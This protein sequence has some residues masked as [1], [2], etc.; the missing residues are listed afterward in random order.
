MKN[1]KKIFPKLLI[2]LVIMI[3]II[4]VFLSLN[5]ISE[6][7]KTLREVRVPWLLAGVGVLFLYLFFY[8]LSLY[9]LGK[10]KDEES[11]SFPNAM[12]IG[13]MEYFFNGIT[14]F[15]A[16]GQPFQ[17][18]AYNQIGVKPHRS[19][20]IILLNFVATQLSIVLLCLISLIYYPKLT[21][22]K[23]YLKVMIWI[24]L[25]MNL[26]ILF[27]FVSVGISKTLRNWITRLVHWFLNLKIFKGKLS[28]YVEGF[29]NYCDGAQSTFKALSKEKG[30]FC[31]CVLFKLISFIL[32]YMIPFFILKALSIEV[33]ASD[34]ILITAMTTFSIA[35]TCY[36]PT[37]GAAGGI[38]FAFQSLFITILPQISSSIAASGVLLWRFITYY[39]LMFISFI[40]YLLFEWIVKRR[41]NQANEA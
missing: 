4:I 29:E 27:L 36:I 39:L 32:Y 9:L 37:P 21:M 14:P 31:C 5:D 24:G 2:V 16:G 17:I 22:N 18:Y 6:I 23:V 7:A 8:P 40:I 33:G 11:V 19:S 12:M 38:E 41:N 3:V 34:I 10:T 30:K 25:A 28:K 15:S 35:M 20:G 26:F 13:S 1:F